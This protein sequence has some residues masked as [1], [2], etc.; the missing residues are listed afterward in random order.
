MLHESIFFGDKPD[1]TAANIVIAE[2]IYRWAEFRT[3]VWEYHI[4]LISAQQQIFISYD[5]FGR[6]V[7]EYGQYRPREFHSDFSLS[8]YPVMHRNRRN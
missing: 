5:N 3:I 2:D 8:L 1:V 4:S 7:Q 6:N